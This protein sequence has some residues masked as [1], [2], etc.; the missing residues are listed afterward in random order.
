[1]NEV[2]LGATALWSLILISILAGFLTVSVYRRW[3]NHAAIRA[4]ANQ[5]L[6]HVM[7]F[8]LFLDEP[9]LILRAQRDLFAANWRLLLLLLRPTLILLVPFAVLLAAMEAHYARAPLQIGRP[10]LVTAQL[11]SGN[12]ADVVLKTPKGI[13]VETPGVHIPRLNQ[14]SWRIRPVRPFS[15]KIQVIGGKIAWVAVQY[16]PARIFHLHWLVWFVIISTAT[17]IASYGIPGILA[18]INAA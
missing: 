8:R 9:A 5:M 4:A 17:A 16:P 3:T 7:E 2:D 13:A 18:R 14:I 12:R 11:K 1:M 6:A 15:G 10:T